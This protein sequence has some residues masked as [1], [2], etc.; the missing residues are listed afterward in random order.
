MPIITQRDLVIPYPKKVEL[1]IQFNYAIVAIHNSFDYLED[2]WEDI[3]YTIA[4]SITDRGITILNATTD[5]ND[6]YTIIAYNLTL[7]VSPPYIN[8][9]FIYDELTVAKLPHQLRLTTPNY[10]NNDESDILLETK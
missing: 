2:L 5:I 1:S 6:D 3:V 8:F 10:Y 4:K 9:T 7:L